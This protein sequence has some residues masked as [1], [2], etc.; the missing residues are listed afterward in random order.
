MPRARW[1]QQQT[2]ACRSPPQT[3]R[4]C[5]SSSERSMRT[6]RSRSGTDIITGSLH[7]GFLWHLP[8]GYCATEATRKSRNLLKYHRIY[9]SRAA[10]V[11]VG[12]KQKVR[13]NF[14]V[15]VARWRIYPSRAL[16][17]VQSLGAR[18]VTTPS[19][20]H[21]SR[22]RPYSGNRRRPLHARAISRSLDQSKGSNS[23]WCNLSN[24]IS[25]SRCVRLSWS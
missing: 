15:F 16:L 1:R 14:V 7:H 19:A 5:S 17:A 20:D 13:R 18:L 8:P 12:S 3:V 24:S 9:P 25:S 22:R 11:S 6:S 4:P 10:D 2:K 21:R 23:G